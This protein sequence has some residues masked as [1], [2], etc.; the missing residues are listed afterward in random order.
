MVGSGQDQVIAPRRHD[1]LRLEDSGPWRG[2]G[3]LGVSLESSEAIH[4][5]LSR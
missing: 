5:Q 1:G 3:Q 4:T 2:T